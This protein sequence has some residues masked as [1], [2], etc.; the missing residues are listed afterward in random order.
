MKDLELFLELDEK[1]LLEVNG[2]STLSEWICWLAGVMV[3]C[4][5]SMAEKGVAGHEIMGSK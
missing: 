1:A 2:G 5:T 3:F 4:P